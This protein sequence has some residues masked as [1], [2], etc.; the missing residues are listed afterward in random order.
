M[1]NRHT[2]KNRIRRRSWALGVPLA[3][4]V[5]ALVTLATPS[6][7]RASEGGFL[8]PGLL[9]GFM[10]GPSPAFGIGGELSYMH[11]WGPVVESPGLGVFA[12]AQSY[13]NHGRYAL[14]VQ[15]GNYLGL[16]LGAAF[17]EES[18]AHGQTWGIHIAGYASIGLLELGLRG[19][20]PVVL[21]DTP[22]KPAHGGEIGLV[23]GVKLPIPIGDPDVIDFNFIGGRPLRV[24][25]RT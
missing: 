23:L 6:T 22:E 20:I 25:D 3:G 24:G 11:Y 8:N 17:R 2:C 15:G 19:T 14:G 12:Q 7:A 9:L 4:A 1:S 10:T 13:G 21:V 5:G 16:E 18:V